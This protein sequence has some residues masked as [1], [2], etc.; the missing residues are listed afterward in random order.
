MPAF[1]KLL[2]SV[3]SLSVNAMSRDP[4]GAGAPDYT[5]TTTTGYTTTT[6]NTAYNITSPTPPDYN[7]PYDMVGL[8]PADSCL[9]RIF[10][11]RLHHGNKIEL[12][13]LR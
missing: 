7:Y 11:N 6:G 13:L 3:L 5:T 9:I 1:L 4:T 12:L 8:P 2:A 10:S